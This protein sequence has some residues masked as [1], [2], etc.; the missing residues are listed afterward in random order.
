MCGWIE[1]SCSTAF[2][3]ELNGKTWWP[4]SRQIVTMT[5]TIAG[6][7]SM[8][9]IFAIRSAENISNLR[10]EKGKRKNYAGSP[11][12]IIHGTSPVKLMTDS[13]ALDVIAIAGI[14]IMSA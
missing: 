6:S 7:S 9:T 5:S 1:S 14:A 3:A 13:Y 4:F 12:T 11:A 2:V 8:I 10:K